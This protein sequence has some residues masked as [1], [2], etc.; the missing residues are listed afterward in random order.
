MLSS[1]VVNYHSN[2]PCDKSHNHQSM[3]EPSTGGTTIQLSPAP[4]SDLSQINS[5]WFKLQEGRGT[6][7]GNGQQT[8]PA[9]ALYVYGTMEEEKNHSVLFPQMFVL[10]FK[11]LVQSQQVLNKH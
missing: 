2:G 1:S 10:K 6:Q 11:H 7:M 5:S 8:T 4:I 9:I 3:S